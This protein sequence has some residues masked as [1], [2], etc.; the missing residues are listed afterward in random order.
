MYTK[1]A[2]AGRSSTVA[3]WSVR[4]KMTTRNPLTTQYRM[5]RRMV[6]V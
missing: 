2:A 1:A 6:I 5:F 3:R 4:K